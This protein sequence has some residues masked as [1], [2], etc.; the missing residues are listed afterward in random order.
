MSAISLCPFCKSAL[1]EHHDECR[2]RDNL[3][4]LS[5]V[6]W[7]IHGDTNKA[8]LAERIAFYI[9]PEREAATP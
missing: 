5:R 6:Y 4:M 8:T 3:P 7:R 1:P 2:I 9:S